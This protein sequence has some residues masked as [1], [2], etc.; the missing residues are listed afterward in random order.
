MDSTQSKIPLVVLEADSK[1]VGKGIAR[2]D[3][4]VMEKLKLENG[5]VIYI[6]GKRKTV[7]RVSQGS[8]QDWG[9]HVIRL[10]H[11]IR[12][13]ANVKIGEI[14]Y[15]EKTQAYVASLLKI[16]PYKYATPMDN[17]VKKYIK[18]KL[19]GRVVIKDDVVYIKFPGIP[20]SLPF[21]V[22]YTK[23]RGPVIIDEDTELIVL[24][25][26]TRIPV[27]TYEDIGGL[28]HVIRRIK[29]LVELPLR[30]P[31]IFR[32]LGIEPPRGILLYGPPGCGKTLLA[33]A[34]ANETN[35]YFIS[36]NGPE[37]MSKYY[38]ESE[39]KLREIF[40]QAKKNAPAIIFVDEI[41]SIAPKREEVVGEVEKRVVAQLLTL[42]DGLESRGDVI[43]IAATNRPNAVD[44]AL[45][46]PGRFDVEIEVPM[47]D[48]KGRL[49]ILQIHTRNTPLGEDV[50]LVKIA[51]M[52]HGYT[53]AD[54]AALVKEAALA[55][56]RRILP[57]IDIDLDNIPQDI[58]DKIE[59]KMED[60]INA[61]KRIIPSGLREVYVEVPEVK[62][63]DI[64]GL[65]EVK[66]ELREM[67]EW[68]LK[69]PLVFKRMGIS[70]PRGI[71]LTGPPGCGKTLLAKAA[72]HES[73]ANLIAVRG[74]EVLSK[75]VGES[76]RAIREIFNK[77]RMYAPAIILFDEIESIAPARG[78]GYDSFV[79][80]RVV[81]QLLTEMSGIE[82]LENV[83]VIGATNRPDLMDPALLRPGRFDKII[84][85]PPPD[86]KSRLE[87]LKIHTRFT[88]LAEDV[89]LEELAR[90]TEGYSGADLEALVR[91]AVMIALR[92]NM[93]S[94]VVTMKHFEKAL[95]NVK[96][97]ITPEIMK[98]YQEWFSRAKQRIVSETKKP[99]VQM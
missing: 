1:D 4:Y 10:D 94:S 90:R 71:I 56:L 87:I 12:K 79:T 78:Y 13:N 89:D 44:P 27:V 11:N 84:Y 67:I 99:I 76:E 33:K 58:Y 7:A 69:Y 65:E 32:R 72:A 97:S 95:E 92:E 14:V 74:P 81:S 50:D 18:R 82:K 29:E 98:F 85:I 91:E 93:D 46:R 2:V 8:T 75:W 15:I 51:E 61:M 43:V 21:T 39:Q 31:D 23:P 38:G 63:S 25:K 57:N 6:E 28:S 66:Q 19:V 24:D 62:W 3:P 37:I 36:I 49:E 54:L 20:E 88:P 83:V 35:S 53:G 86:Y 55:A 52:T 16:T 9:L 96:P 34:I 30:Y 60:F 48:K 40:E 5:D 68:P 26:P 59:I 41:D 17:E 64:G 80:E 77:A 45:R 70:P 42:M 73:G 22:V 47:P